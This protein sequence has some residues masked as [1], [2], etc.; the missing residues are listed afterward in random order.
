MKE[1]H[2]NTLY[3]FLFP[4]NDKYLPSVGYGTHLKDQ[5]GAFVQNNITNSF[6][7]A[8]FSFTESSGIS[9]E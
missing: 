5:S 3:R 7:C 8:I 1:D 4:L 9:I 2:L 6:L